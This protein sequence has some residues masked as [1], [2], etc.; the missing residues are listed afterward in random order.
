M[1]L[2]SS[3]T[4]DFVNN[5]FVSKYIENHCVLERYYVSMVYFVVSLIIT[6]AFSIAF[7]AGKTEKFHLAVFLT[8][9]FLLFQTPSYIYFTGD[10]FNC[11]SDT[12]TILE[13]FRSSPFASLWLIPFSIYFEVLH[14]AKEP[15]NRFLNASH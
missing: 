9:Q 7:V 8:V 10:F 4:L 2:S 15:I 13:V 6:L 11:I 5:H 14:N 3:G 1:I 12:F